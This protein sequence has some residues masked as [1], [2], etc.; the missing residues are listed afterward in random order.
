MGSLVVLLASALLVAC[1]RKSEGHAAPRQVTLPAR[2]AGAEAPAATA[3]AEALAA[4][5]PPLAP[6]APSAARAPSE[7][8]PVPASGRVE[9]EPAEAPPPPEAALRKQRSALARCRNEACVLERIPID[10]P[11]PFHEKA[12]SVF[13]ARKPSPSDGLDG[14]GL[15]CRMRIAR[16]RATFRKQSPCATGNPGNP[17]FDSSLHEDARLQVYDDLLAAKHLKA[18]GLSQP[19]T[20]AGG[21]FTLHGTHIYRVDLSTSDERIEAQAFFCISGEPKHYVPYLFSLKQEPR[22]G[23]TPAKRPEVVTEYVANLPVRSPHVLFQL[24]DINMFKTARYELVDVNADR[25]DDL[26]LLDDRW[27]DPKYPLRVCLFTSGA[28]QCRMLEVDTRL[29]PAEP[30]MA[31]VELSIEQGRIITR[32]SR[33]N[34]GDTLARAEYRVNGGELERIA[35]P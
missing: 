32:L 13:D 24:G 27:S 10:A 16:A 15:V 12:C 6:D 22:H 20:G 29:E 23:R 19:L 2:P 7:P 4:G 18:R 14:L 30:E 35:L 25:F 9:D 33:P 5:E 3:A 26:V 1:N 28:E 11:P 8:T 31:Q 34:G 21:S 17:D